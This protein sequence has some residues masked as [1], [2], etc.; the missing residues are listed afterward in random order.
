MRLSTLRKHRRVRPA[1]VSSLPLWWE[2]VP[3]SYCGSGLTSR[4]SS[5]AELTL[6]SIRKAYDAPPTHCEYV[7]SIVVA[8]SI[9]QTDAYLPR[10]D[11]RS[12]GMPT[13]TP[14]PSRS[15]PWAL[16]AAEQRAPFSVHRVEMIV[17]GV[18]AWKWGAEYVTADSRE[19][20]YIRTIRCGYSMHKNRL[21]AFCFANA[22]TKPANV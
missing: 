20:Y 15:C 14:H 22:L 3:A 21:L 1:S 5:S 2:L 9:Y 10:R 18:E 12:Q 8:S 13:T 6:S 11:C 19:R 16:R 7:H 17:P 4:R